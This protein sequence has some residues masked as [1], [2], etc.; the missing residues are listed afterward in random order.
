MS[1]L[2]FPK[3]Q[4]PASLR[5]LLAIRA[6]RQQSLPV[7]ATTT[8]LAFAGLA[9]LVGGTVLALQ[10]LPSQVITAGAPWLIAIVAVSADASCCASHA[11]TLLAPPNNAAAARPINTF[12]MSR[13]FADATR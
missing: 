3:K 9:L 7:H 11:R 1:G 8:G 10:D 6:G 12:L 13:S 5:A 2:F 4:K